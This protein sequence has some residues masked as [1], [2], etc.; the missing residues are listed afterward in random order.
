ME[1]NDENE[2]EL[3][4]EGIINNIPKSI[5]ISNKFL[6]ESISENSLKYF[7][8]NSLIMNNSK[9][10]TELSEK[11][12]KNNNILNNTVRIEKGKN[13]LKNE[14]SNS[15]TTKSTINDKLKKVTFSTVEIIRISNFKKYNKL[16]TFKKN[17][18]EKGW[19]D[20]QNC[21]LF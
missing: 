17:E 15:Y 13:N 4:P 16:N 8:Q 14:D 12:F 21:L 2:N 19:L 9:I 1:Y 6:S 20:E 3:E 7:R 5:N 10:K 11:D 18:N